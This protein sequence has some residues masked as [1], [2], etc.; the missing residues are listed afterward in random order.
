MNGDRLDDLLGRAGVWTDPPPH[1]ED[2][3]VE[4]IGRESPGNGPLH[5]Q[6]PPTI[7]REI[8]RPRRRRLALVAAVAAVLALTVGSLGVLRMLDGGAHIDIVGTDLAPDARAVALVEETASG[9]GIVLDVRG[10]PPAAEGRFYQAWMRADDGDLVSVGT[11][12]LRGGDDTVTL[13]GGVSID[14][15]PTLTV[16]VQTV[17]AGSES[18]GEVVIRGALR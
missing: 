1:L 13:W 7:P 12:H 11:F 4:A 2:A 14:S 18:S 6:H 8:A 16:T 10:L 15:H 17:G 9:V 5:R 3:L